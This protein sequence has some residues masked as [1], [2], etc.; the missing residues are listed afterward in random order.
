MFEF[1]NI[2]KNVKLIKHENHYRLED[3]LNHAIDIENINIKT[4]EN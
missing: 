3:Y 1:K 4:D 2:I